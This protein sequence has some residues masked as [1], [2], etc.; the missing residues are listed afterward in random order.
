MYTIR[1]NNDQIS[2]QTGILQARSTNGLYGF[3]VIYC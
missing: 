3:L 2:I 1:L